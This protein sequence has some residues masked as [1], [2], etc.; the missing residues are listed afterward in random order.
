MSCKS[1]SCVPS[2]HG[3][4]PLSISRNAFVVIFTA[5]RC[6]Y[7]CTCPR[8]PCLCE[9][10]REL[11]P[12][13]IASDRV[14]IYWGRKQNL[15][16]RSVCTIPHRNSCSCSTQIYFRL[17]L[18]ALTPG[19]GDNLYIPGARQVS[20]KRSYVHRHSGDIDSLGGICTLI[21]A[22]QNLLAGRINLRSNDEKGD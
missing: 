6:V 8:R 4:F 14:G 1:V 13:M 10:D 5:T 18:V 21:S 3:V 16:L 22:K 19:S 12:A 7:L 2:P 9:A 20:V 15:L 17:H 11:S